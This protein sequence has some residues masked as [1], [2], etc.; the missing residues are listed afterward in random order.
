MRNCEKQPRRKVMG[1]GELCFLN[2]RTRFSNVVDVGFKGQVVIKGDSECSG[3]PG[4]GQ[5]EMINRQ[6]EVV[7]KLCDR[8]RSNDYHV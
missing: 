1:K 5:G 8:F 3:H 7:C 4:M 2:E 6:V